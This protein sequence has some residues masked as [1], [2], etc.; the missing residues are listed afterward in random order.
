MPAELCQKQ[1]LPRCARAPV[2]GCSA[3][4]PRGTELSRKRP[5][6]LNSISGP[7]AVSTCT[8]HHREDPADLT[9]LARVMKNHAVVTV[10]VLLLPRSSAF[11]V[12]QCNSQRRCRV[13]TTAMTMRHSTR[14]AP[15]ENGLLHNRGRRS[16]TSACTISGISCCCVVVRLA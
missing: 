12:Q 11:V 2:F 7:R 15:G 16:S 3:Q 13:G 9:M 4:K 10:V 8:L 6:I 1:L 14:S 5:P